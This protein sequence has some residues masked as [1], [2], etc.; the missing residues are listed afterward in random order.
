MVGR[1]I[2]G[3]ITSGGA[4]APLGIE[5]F[6][7][8]AYVD[9]TA[10][11]SWIYGA[12]GAAQALATY[13]GTLPKAYGVAGEII[14][15]GSGAITEAI[16]LGM[17]P[18]WSAGAITTL[19]GLDIPTLTIA[20]T[21]LLARFGVGTIRHI[22]ALTLA[23]SAAGDLTLTPY[24]GSQVTIGDTAVS[25]LHRPVVIADQAYQTRAL[26]EWL[27]VA[28]V[29]T[30]T[31]SP[32]PT[33]PVHFHFE[34]V[35]TDAN[36][37]FTGF[38]TQVRFGGA[39]LVGANSQ[40]WNFGLHFDGSANFPDPGATEQPP[41]GV[42][43]NV[44]AG[45][46]FTGNVPK[47]VGIWL[48]PRYDAA[49]TGTIPRL[50]MIRGMAGEIA[51]AGKITDFSW[52]TLPNLTNVTNFYL[53]RLGLG[54]ILAEGNISLYGDDVAKRAWNIGKTGGTYPDVVN[55]GFSKFAYG[56]E[57]T[58]SADNL[59][60]NANFE[61]DLDGDGVPDYWT[62][63]GDGFTWV[64]AQA[65]MGKYAIS[66]NKVTAT[67]RATQDDYIPVD[68]DLVYELRAEWYC[69]AAN[70]GNAGAMHLRLE[71]Y[72]ANKANLGEE[73][74]QAFVGTTT[75]THSVMR[76]TSELAGGGATR[77]PVGTR[78]V[79]VKILN[80]GANNSS[81]YVRWIEFKPVW[82][83]A[84]SATITLGNSVVV[85][86]DLCIRSVDYVLATPSL[87]ATLW[88]GAITD[89]TS[90]VLNSSVVAPVGGIVCHYQVLRAN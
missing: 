5:G 24:A 63:S 29:P 86:S 6:G 64:T 38:Q 74:Y 67:A 35:N 33:T 82:R 85:V 2:S 51:V 73:V 17:L 4:N 42:D 11:P 75:P 56:S 40:V 78:F 14:N 79:K 9:A 77:F 43:V 81:T 89:L 54:T 88:R 69:N 22:G 83:W 3:Q 50:D 12:H 58:Q 37:L 45:P 48:H 13:A 36:R 41:S 44:F 10:A 59:V 87:N 39:N 80:A 84:G 27:K 15:E 31:L 65:H 32:G 76:F 71:C 57:D 25:G 72:D 70:N 47:A 61:Y 68:I 23:G 18:I 66:L 28:G 1:A 62:S 60:R 34:P 8:Y 46:N 19:I 7:G 21:N 26:G 49:A 20:T 52:L 55:L 53:A 90:F 16:G 30:L